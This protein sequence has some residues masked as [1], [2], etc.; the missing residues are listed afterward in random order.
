MNP[1]FHSFYLVK[2][3]KTP[4][5]LI[6][7]SILPLS[8][9]AQNIREGKW[10]HCFEATV[11]SNQRRAEITTDLTTSIGAFQI[12]GTDIPEQAFPAI[13]SAFALWSKK[14][15]SATPIKIQMTWTSVE[16]NFLAKTRPVSYRKNFSTSAPP[17]IWYPIA[18]AEKIAG[19]ELNNSTDFEIEITIN[20]A[21]NWY[22]GTDEQV[23]VEEFDLYTIILHELAH[24]LGFVS[25]ASLVSGGASLSSDGHFDIYDQQLVS[26]DFSRLSASNNNPSLLQEKITSEEVFFLGENNNLFKCYTS[27]I[28]LTSISLSHLDEDPEQKKLMTPFFS[29]SEAFHTID[30]STLKVLES[31]GWSDTKPTKVTT[32]YPNPAAEHITFRLPV[33]LDEL[34]ICAYDTQGQKLI[35][36]SSKFSNNALISINIET[37]D[38][39]LYYFTLA[40]KKFQFHKTVRVM[41][42]R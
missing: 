13:D 26:P 12:S 33:Y 25:S 24:G 7:L 28:F 5:L 15:T 18:L 9:H 14:I 17:N 16:G 10:T 40:N 2:S 3:L 11:Q 21:I 20:G 23:G 41:V 39:G 37:L 19:K 30:S 6:L 35:E 29:T 1:T 36:T 27:G 42:K 38:P 4:W 31:I 8:S 32:C 22:Y 34:S